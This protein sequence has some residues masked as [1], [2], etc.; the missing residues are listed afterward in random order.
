MSLGWA[1]SSRS[2]WRRGAPP[3]RSWSWLC[4]A[5]TAAPPPAS[6]SAT[7]SASTTSPAPHCGCPSPGWPPPRPP[8]AGRGGGG[9]RAGRRLLPRGGGK[10]LS[11][12]GMEVAMTA[13]VF[14]YYA[15]LALN[16]KG[17]VVSNY[18]D[19]ALGLILKEP[20]GVVGIIPPWNFP[21]PLVTW[22]AAPALAAGCTIIMKPATYT[23][24]TT[25][26]LGRIL[27]EAG[28]P[29]RRGDRVHSPPA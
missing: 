11:E 21:L 24:C 4:A 15:G 19:D 17:Q 5:S 18:V 29:A 26:E 23:P 6:A 22:K 1:A 3:T 28:A 9:G 7:I 25:Y 13:D 14:D 12:A 10:P 2:P 27:N 20:V 16:V 8:R